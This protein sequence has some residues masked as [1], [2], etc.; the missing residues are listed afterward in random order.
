M[1]AR[2][3]GRVWAYGVSTALI[4]AVLLPVLGPTSSD[5]FPFS[6]YP[7]FSGRRFADVALPHVVVIDAA[8]IRE[9]LPPEALGTDEV[10]QAFET[11]RQAIR[12]GNESLDVLCGSA[13]TW[14]AEH[15]AEHAV[16]VAVVTDT[17]NAIRYFD[18]EKEPATTTTH[19]ECGVP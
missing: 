17:Y 9:P 7:M 1:N 6:T 12:Q 5:S 10:I 18:G 14:V 13:A 4:I 15:Q 16:S 11:V 19:A 3:G 2:P 8:G